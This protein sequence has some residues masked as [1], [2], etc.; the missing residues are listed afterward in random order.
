MGAVT[1]CPPYTVDSKVIQNMERYDIVPYTSWNLPK[2]M[3][4][5]WW[6]REYF[7]L[8]YFRF[9]I[10]HFPSRALRFNCSSVTNIVHILS[11]DCNAVIMCLHCYMF[12]GAL[13]HHQ[14][15]RSCIKQSS[16]LIIVSNV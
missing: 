10:L 2:Q 14:G 16:E 8:I 3:L 12:R 6:L 9:F 4:V 1:V 7:C 11:Y 15:M 5:Q 13:A